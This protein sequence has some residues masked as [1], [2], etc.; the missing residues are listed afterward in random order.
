MRESEIKQKWQ[1]VIKKTNID[2]KYHDDIEQYLEY[3]YGENIKDDKLRNVYI[4]IISSTLFIL[5]RIDLSKVQFIYD[6]KMV[7]EKTIIVKDRDGYSLY[8]HSDKNRVIIDELLLKINED[9]SKYK[10]III[11]KLINGIFKENGAFEQKY[12]LKSKYSN[13]LEA[14]LLK[15]SKLKYEKNI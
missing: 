13:M 8:T 12:V 15:I 11:Y 6:D 14:R 7:H 3:H 10:G 4:D 5:L 2:K 1:Y 9:I